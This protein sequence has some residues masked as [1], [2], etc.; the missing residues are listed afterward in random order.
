MFSIA[1]RR[2]FTRR[3]LFSSALKSFSSFSTST[4]EGQA[5]ENAVQKDTPTGWRRFFTPEGSQAD[6]SYKNRWFMALPAFLTHICIGSPWAW[7]VMSSTVSRELGFVASSSGDWSMMQT[8]IPLSIIFFMQGVGATIGG[9]WQAKVGP[10]AAIAVAGGCFGLGMML[11]A[12]GIAMHSLPLLYLG[13]GL[14]GG[15][16]VGLSYTPPI[17]ALIQW[18]PDRRGLA[19]GMTSAGFGS[20]ALLFTPM[21]NKLMDKFK[22]L[23]EY[24]GPQGEVNVE[25]RDGKSVASVVS[26]MNE[27]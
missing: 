16:G 22:K 5:N 8:T 15:T 4:T 20:G 6:E 13:Y 21:V 19:A 24:L 25:N 27:L 1:A 18:F 9:K 23:P 11:G 10:R 7:S 14:L 26:R 2:T 12:A 17:Q 3:P